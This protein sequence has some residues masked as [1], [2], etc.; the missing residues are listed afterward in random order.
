MFGSAS[1]RAIKFVLAAS[2]LIAL[3]FSMGCGPKYPDC[4]SDEHCKER[5]EYC[6]NKMCRPCADDSHC[7]TND[8]CK[9]CGEGYTCQRQSGCCTSDLDCP[10]GKCYSVEGSVT[11][12]CGPKCRSGADCP[13]GTVCKNGQC[14]P[15]VECNSDA[16]CPAGKKCVNGSCVMSEC[17][18][19]AVYF[20][21]DDANIR[22]DQKPTLESNADC[23]KRRNQAVTVEGHCDERGTDEYNMALGQRRARSA[24][25]Y[26]QNLGVSG[27]VRTISYGEERPV[28]S[29]SSEDCWSRNRRA[30]FQF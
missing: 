3:V 17:V 4:S 27:N 2:T 13:P 7:S 28:C 19:E 24:Q 15:D 12:E 8:A 20:D 5:G 6:V 14:V 22:R 21:F 11:G 10:G 23:I 9:F 16:D 18:A 29:T 26:L 1:S 25:R 30:E